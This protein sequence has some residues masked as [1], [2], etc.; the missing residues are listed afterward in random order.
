MQE[1]PHEFLCSD[2]PEDRTENQNCRWFSIYQLSTY[3]PAPINTQSSCLAYATTYFFPTASTEKR[4]KGAKWEGRSHRPY[5]SF[6]LP[7]I[8]TVRSL[9][10]FDLEP[11]GKKIFSQ[12][13]WFPFLSR[14]RVL[15]HHHTEALAVGSGSDFAR[16]GLFYSQNQLFSD[17]FFL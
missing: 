2:G 16:S 14:I 8:S 11:S 10:S 12:K 4:Q 15:L 3:S 17:F 7:P 5:R 6:V 13:S 9:F 1:E